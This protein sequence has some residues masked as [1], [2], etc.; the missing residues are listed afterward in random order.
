MP[1]Y[2]FIADKLFF[3]FVYVWRFAGLKVG[4]KSAKQIVEDTNCKYITNDDVPLISV[5]Y[6]NFVYL[7]S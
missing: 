1:A 3:G 6:G 5:S 7:S 2:I 4:V